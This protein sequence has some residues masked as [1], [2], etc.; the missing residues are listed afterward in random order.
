MQAN[1]DT[2]KTRDDAIATRHGRDCSEL[3]F[4]LVTSLG[5]TRLEKHSASHVQ[6]SNPLQLLE[7]FPLTHPLGHSQAL[8]IYFFQLHPCTHPPPILNPS[9]VLSLVLSTCRREMTFLASISLP[10]E[11]IKNGIQRHTNPL[12]QLVL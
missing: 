10:A 12:L 5:I 1:Q 7:H 3:R 2:V 8:T 9:C 6:F 11:P 4:R